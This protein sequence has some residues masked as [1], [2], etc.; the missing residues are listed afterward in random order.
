VCD[1]FCI[2]S[3]YE[4]CDRGHGE[5]CDEGYY[6]I[7]QGCCRNGAECAGPPTGC[8]EEAM[9]CDDICIPA[10]NICCNTGSGSFCE[11]GDVCLSSGKCG[12]TGSGGSDGS[13]NPL[14]DGKTV[15]VTATPTETVRRG[16]NPLPKT[17]API[18]VD[19]GGGGG[20]GQGYSLAP[21]NSNENGETQTGSPQAEP[22]GDGDDNSNS[23]SQAESDENNKG[24]STGAGVAVT[25]PTAA[26]VWVLAVMAFTV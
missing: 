9:L 18:E 12:R 14:A 3:T 11:K 21:V 6:C 20:G 23:D 2:E 8:T 16:G 24:D 15:T 19:V 10:G 5:A 4:C 25:V 1:I 13:P 26:I 17:S 7:E 22:T